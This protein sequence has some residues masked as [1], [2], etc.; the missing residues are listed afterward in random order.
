MDAKQTAFVAA[1]VE[2]TQIESR[3]DNQSVIT[4]RT[5]SVLGKTNIFV[6]GKVEPYA[7]NLPANVM[8][9]DLNRV[10]LRYK[11]ILKRVS[12]DPDSLFGTEHT[13]VAVQSFSEMWYD[14]FYDIGDIP[15][16]DI[17]PATTQSIGTVTLSVTPLI[18]VES[19]TV[20]SSTDPRN[21]DP[22]NPL[23]HLAMH[24]E[25]PARMLK[26]TGRTVFINN[27]NA[28]AN[29]ALIAN[30]S[31]DSVYRKLLLEE[32]HENSPAS[33]P[34]NPNTLSD[35]PVSGEL[36]FAELE[37]EERFGGVD[38]GRT[39]TIAVKAWG[40]SDPDTEFKVFLGTFFATTI[41][42]RHNGTIQPFSGNVLTVTQD[43]IYTVT[44][45]LVDTNGS[46]SVIV[47]GAIL[48][49]GA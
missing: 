33:A 8:W 28:E 26:T 44:A 35:P 7:L 16:G 38:I 2:F 27:G 13:W 47:E 42:V 30:T 12:K 19:P 9:I 4:K 23:P 46:S 20:V 31:G 45:T 29:F 24:P 11:Q 6:C 1:L 14:Q 10:S 34:A 25:I 48:V 18:D 36:Y 15:T 41:E 40:A 49:N 39:F 5:N 3:T 32:V 43:G 17:G 22:R 37:A 21:T